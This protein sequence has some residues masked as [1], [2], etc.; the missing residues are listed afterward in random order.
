[1]NMVT[2]SAMMVDDVAKPWQDPA[3]DTVEKVEV[4][5]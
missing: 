4:M 3:T 5:V 1:V 2:I